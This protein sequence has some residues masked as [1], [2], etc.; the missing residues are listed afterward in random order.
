MESSTSNLSNDAQ[1]QV[2]QYKR[3]AE[4]A[5][6]LLENVEKDRDSSYEDCQRL[7]T[8]L[9][10]FRRQQRVLSNAYQEKDEVR[11]TV[12]ISFRLQTSLSFELFTGLGQTSAADSCPY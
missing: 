11:E 8:T 2:D 10:R 4:K 5:E 6:A 9:S 7:R 3:R 1:A 12:L